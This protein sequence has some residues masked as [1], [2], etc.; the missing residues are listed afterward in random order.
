MAEAVAQVEYE[1][2]VQQVGHTSTDHL[3]ETDPLSAV[4]SARIISEGSQSAFQG[5]RQM[6]VVAKLL[7][8]H[9]Y[10]HTSFKRATSFARAWNAPLLLAKAV[11]VISRKPK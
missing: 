10:Q 2:V 9:G 3:A 7:R 6:G 11:H 8:R 1:L 4:K 5:E